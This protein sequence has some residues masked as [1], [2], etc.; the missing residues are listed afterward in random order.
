MANPNPSHTMPLCKCT[1]P[2][3]WPRITFRTPPLPLDPVL[4]TRANT[5]EP[6][7][8]SAA[9][10]Q[11]CLSQSEA[12]GLRCLGRRGPQPPPLGH[13]W[14]A[15]RVPYRQFAQPCITLGVHTSPCHQIKSCR[16]APIP[17]PPASRTSWTCRFV[18]LHLPQPTLPSTPL[19]LVF[20]PLIFVFN[21]ICHV[22][23]TLL[24]PDIAG[25]S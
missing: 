6:S 25:S 20:H 11:S 19:P 23:P 10:T 22:S 5:G 13:V 24:S 3:H 16:R 21:P 1:F 12:Q 17:L 18:V 2:C 9:R 4:G 7:W 8:P 15:S 14:I